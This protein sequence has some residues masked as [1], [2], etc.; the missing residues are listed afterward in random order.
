VTSADRVLFVSDCH[1]G[2]GTPAED[3]ARQDRLVTF[4]ESEAAAASSLFLLGD[5]FDIWF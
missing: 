2:A 4:L 1:L 5:L 3:A